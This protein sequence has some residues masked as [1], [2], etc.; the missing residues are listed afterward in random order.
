M[1]LIDKSTACKRNLQRAGNTFRTGD[2][3]PAAPSKAKS[4]IV[5]VTAP[6]VVVVTVIIKLTAVVAKVPQ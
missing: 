6:R 2:T 1:R 4:V 5:A 3:L